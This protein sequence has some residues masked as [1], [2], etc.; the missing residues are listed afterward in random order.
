MRIIINRGLCSGCGI[1]EA[2]APDIFQIGEDSKSQLISEA[3]PEN[4]EN[5]I[6]AKQNCPEE[7]I[8]IEN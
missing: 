2:F 8:T 5:I 3:T 4:E 1:C 6:E 7:A